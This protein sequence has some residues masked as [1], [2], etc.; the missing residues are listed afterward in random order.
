MHVVVCGREV[1][2]HLKSGRAM[3]ND[4]GYFELETESISLKSSMPVA[5][6]RRT[7]SHECFHAFLYFTGYNELLEDI[8]RNTEEALTRAFDAGMGDMLMFPDESG[9]V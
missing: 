6:R 9:P 7:L 3:K 4:Y 8:S 2:V 1:P 5:I